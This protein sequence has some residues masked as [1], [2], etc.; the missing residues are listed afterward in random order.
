MLLVS[1]LLPALLIAIYPIRIFRS[2]LLKFIPGGRSR[3]TLNIFVEKFYS[4]YRDGLDGG[5]DMRSFASLYLF[6]RMFS[7]LLIQS[8]YLTI[9]FGVCCLVIAL[10]RPYKKTYMNNIDVLILALLTFN[11]IQVCNFSSASIKSTYYE[12]NFWGMTATAYLPLL[13]VSYNIL[14]SKRLFNLMKQKVATC[15]KFCCTKNE[16]INMGVEVSDND[17]HDPQGY[18]M[19]HPD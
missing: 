8:M 17:G 3:A 2:A 16:E 6:L 10:V 11:C 14:P 13:V 1:G 15:K 4:C 18:R 9:L 19:V 5:K 12:L 7:F